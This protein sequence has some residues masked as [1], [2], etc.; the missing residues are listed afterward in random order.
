MSTGI[1]SP[2]LEDVEIDI[3]DI[4]EGIFDP[5]RSHDGLPREQDDEGYGTEAQGRK[6]RSSARESIQDRQIL[7]PGPY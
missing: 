7:S 5:F 3:S 1:L 2:K 4:N 6:I